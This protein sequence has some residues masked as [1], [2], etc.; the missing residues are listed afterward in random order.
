M[1]F[2]S[3]S[4]EMPAAQS[5]DL[6]RMFGFA[7]KEVADFYGPGHPETLEASGMLAPLEEIV[8]CRDRDQIVVPHEH[9]ESMAKLAEITLRSQGIEYEFCTSG[10]DHE[11]RPELRSK[12]YR[13][14]A[15]AAEI[16]ERV[17]IDRK[18]KE[19]TRSLE[20]N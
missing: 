14:L 19:L 13:T 5:K 11:F 10:Y 6:L 4:L 12:A 16:S 15:I 3:E 17:R 9:W 8:S 18:F 7:V 2:T 20:N 1:K